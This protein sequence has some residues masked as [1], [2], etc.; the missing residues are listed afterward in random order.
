LKNPVEITIKHLSEINEKLKKA[1]ERDPSLPYIRMLAPHVRIFKE[2]DG[3]PQYQ[4]LMIDES[5]FALMQL[6]DRKGWKFQQQVWFEV[7]EK[8]AM[9]AV[10]G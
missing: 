3:Q 5:Q 4:K 6:C 10:N 9:E 2:G 7:S 8:E 1:H